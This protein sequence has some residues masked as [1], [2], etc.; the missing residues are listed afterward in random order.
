MDPIT[1]VDFIDDFESDKPVTLKCF[2]YKYFRERLRGVLQAYAHKIYRLGARRPWESKYNYDRRVH[3]ICE[4]LNRCTCNADPE[5]DKISTEPD[6]DLLDP[7]EEYHA[8]LDRHIAEFSNQFQEIAYCIDK[9]TLVNACK[10]IDNDKPQTFRGF[11]IKF[12]TQPDFVGMVD[13]AN[14]VYR[15]DMRCP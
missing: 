10:D 9:I 7:Q 14:H 11:L 8:I 5:C 4:H 3:I 13:Y 6:T 15:R 2:A 1:L 12:Q